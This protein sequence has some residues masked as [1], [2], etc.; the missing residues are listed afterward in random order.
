MSLER[1]RA[2]ESDIRERERERERK[3]ER[4]RER[5]RESE[6]IGTIYSETGVKQ[7]DETR[8]E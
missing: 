2:D 7:G 5:E 6:P 3:R 1:Q 8:L 4:E